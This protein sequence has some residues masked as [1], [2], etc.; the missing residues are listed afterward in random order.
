MFYIFIAEE[1]NP[2]NDVVSKDKNGN[3]KNNKLFSFI[4]LK[5]FNL[6]IFCAY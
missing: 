6:S 2:D 3:K 5:L 1:F 4:S